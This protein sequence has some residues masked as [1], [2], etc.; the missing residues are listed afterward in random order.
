MER[1]IIKSIS[2]QFGEK[3]IMGDRVKG[4][5]TVQIDDISGIKIV[6][7]TL[8]CGNRRNPP[9]CF[10]KLVDKHGMQDHGFREVLSDSL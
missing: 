2:F 5:P 8:L 9:K 3:D 10:V 4:L 1:S 6:L 7:H